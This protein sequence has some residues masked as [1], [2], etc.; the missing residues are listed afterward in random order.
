[1]S[2]PVSKLNIARQN[3]R[4]CVIII[5][6][7][8]MSVALVDFVMEDFNVNMDMEMLDSF[9]TNVGCRTKVISF[10]ILEDPILE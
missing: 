4:D 10:H 9:Y 7:H 1:M 8:H 6:S 5:Y 2:I 3:Y